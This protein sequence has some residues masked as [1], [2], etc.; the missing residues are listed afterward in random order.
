LERENDFLVKL[1]K[2]LRE[3]EEEEALQYF[4]LVRRSASLDEIRERLTGNDDPITLREVT[5]SSS[6]PCYE[7]EETPATEK[8]TRRSMELTRLTDIPLPDVPPAP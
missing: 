2:T 3:S 1:V 7:V 4:H 6:K 8:D 5:A